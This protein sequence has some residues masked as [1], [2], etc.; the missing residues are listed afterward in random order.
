MKRGQ[1]LVGAWKIAKMYWLSEERLMA[2]WLLFIVIALNLGLVYITVQVNFWHAA[3]Y[4]AIQD[5]NYQEFI[6]VILRYAWL[7][8]LLVIMRG[9]QIYTRML[10]HIRWRNWLT[11]CYIT[12]WLSSKTY[13]KLQFI[14]SDKADNPD[15]RISEDIEQFV[16]L[17]LRLSIDLLHDFVTII[18]F[19]VILWDLS[20]IIYVS[21]IPVP[22]YLVWAAFLFAGLGTYW[23]VALGKPLVWLDYNQQRYEADFRYSLVRMRE[24]I[25][26]IAMYNG[27]NFE[28]K[29]F[30]ERFR[31]IAGN[32]LMIAS[33]R[34]KL[35]WIT[36]TYTQVSVVF[37]I[38]VASPKYFSNQILLGQLFQ[39]IDAY[40]HVQN[41]FSFII[42]SFTRL[43]QWRAVINRLNNFLFCMELSRREQKGVLLESH[44]GSSFFVDNLTVFRP[45]GYQ[46]AEKIALELRRGQHLLVAGP[47]GCGKS[48]LLR[49]LSGLWPFAKGKIYASHGASILFIPQKPYM[50]LNSLR[51]VILYPGLTRSGIDDTC[52]KEAMIHCRLEHLLDKLDHVMDWGQILS[53]GEQQRVAFARAILYKPNWL[54]LDEATSALDEETENVVYSAMLKLLTNTTLISVGHRKTIRRFHVQILKLTGNGQWQLEQLSR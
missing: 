18:S 32:F 2:W 31:Y 15:Q 10:L 29:N 50:P 47:S 49:T 48:T 12:A 53:L 4:Q 27:E 45:D 38:L 51:E 20:G 30:A 54:F 5:Y 28:K 25:E 52:I 24:N 34:K 37:G 14:N 26:S 13:Y 40:S 19:V 33:L 43:A 1:I 44:Q 42:D 23:T 41:G 9:Y 22:G 46:L 3:F 35:T 8:T 17:T 36:S 11:N 21:N 6:K 39:V 16:H 7:A